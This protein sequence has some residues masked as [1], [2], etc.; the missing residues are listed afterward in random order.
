MPTADNQVTWKCCS[1]CSALHYFSLNRNMPSWEGGHFLYVG[2]KYTLGLE[3]QIFAKIHLV[4]GT[5]MVE[6]YSYFKAVHPN[7]KL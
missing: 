6:T 4:L 2:N 3:H 7:L 5:S 1:S